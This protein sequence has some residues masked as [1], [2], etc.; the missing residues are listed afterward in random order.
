MKKMFFMVMLCACCTSLQAQV[1]RVQ[2][3]ERPSLGP[4]LIVESFTGSITKNEI[5]VFKAHIAA[6]EPPKYAGGNVYVYGNPGKLLEACGLM[7]EATGDQ[8]ILD[9]MI[10]FA[11]A[12]LAGRNDLASAENNGQQIAWTGKIEPMWPSSKPG[13][14]PADGGVASGSV[15]AHLLYT[16]KLIL[17]KPTIW[18]QN[19][20]FG[21][22]HN[23]GPAYQERALT[24]VRQADLV[25]AQWL[26]PNYVRA[27]K[28]FYFPGAPNT[29]KPTEAVPWNQMFMFT[30][31]LIRL[32]ACHE[33][34]KDAPDKVKIYD[35]LVK[36]NINWFKENVKS[37]VSPLGTTCWKFDYALISRIEDTNHFAYESEGMWL[38]YTAGKYGVTLADMTIMANTYFDVVLA[39]VKDGRFAGN[40]DGTTG[41]GHAGGDTY[42]RDEYIYLADIRKEKYLTIGDIEQRSGKIAVSPQ[43]TARLLWLKNKRLKEGL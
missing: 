13:I 14:T 42:V 15:I 31:G 18:K 10:Y 27:D 1:P 11:D 20:P 24:Y 12:L 29:Y 21:D 30:N 17:T 41:K 32:S 16:A 7:Y 6:V 9:R 38:A 19:V 37:Y 25:A 40:V 2:E 8:E 5:N 3:T 43:I 36:V 33:L 4:E 28:K 26:I 39:T 22:V 34:L 23:F 35:E